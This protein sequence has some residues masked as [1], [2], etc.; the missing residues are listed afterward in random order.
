MRT[1]ADV[2]GEAVDHHP[3]RVAGRR[4]L[5]LLDSRLPVDAE[6][7]FGLAG[8]NAILLGRAR[9]RAGVERHADG[10]H[11]LD[12]APGGLRHRLQIRSL[13]GE[14]PGDLVDEQRSRDP[15]RLRKIRQGYVVVHHHHLDLQA[16]GPGAFG[17]EAEIQPVPGVVLDDQQA[18]GLARNGEN[19]GE[20][21]V[22]GGRGEDLAAN[23]GCQHAPAD[24]PRMARLVAGASA[25]DQRDLRPVPVGS[26]RD[27]DVRIAVQAREAPAGGAK[28]A[29]D[30]FGDQRFLGVDELFHD[31]SP[32]ATR[33]PAA[34]K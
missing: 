11:A 28:G 21:R 14:R 6:A 34:S 19:A 25:G 1:R 3:H 17:R 8:R 30:R 10:R 27:L 24:E 32:Q 4:E 15:A 9:N 5:D 18:P 20:H 12:D 2:R 13:F 7:Q 22:H 23:G 29:V 33:A 26:F 16:V 31:F